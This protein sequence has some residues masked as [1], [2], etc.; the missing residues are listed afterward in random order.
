MSQSISAKLTVPLRISRKLTSGDALRYCSLRIDELWSDRTAHL[1]SRTF[2][3]VARRG[4]HKD[5]IGGKIRFR[6]L[7]QVVE[8][9][10]LGNWAFHF[11][12]K[13]TR[14]CLSTELYLKQ[15]VLSSECAKFARCGKR[16]C[17]LLVTEEA[18]PRRSGGSL[19]VVVTY[20]RR[21]Y[22]L[23]KQTSFVIKI[24][25]NPESNHRPQMPLY[26]HRLLLS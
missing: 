16:G 13:Q 9:S 6:Q 10:Y 22:N 21:L 15:A 1:V 14:N 25:K 26:H 3:L 2:C 20:R 24:K 4:N 11:P 7:P 23:Q 5:A 17:E 8:I 18:R 19:P 12:R